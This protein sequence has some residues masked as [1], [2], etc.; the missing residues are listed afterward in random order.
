MSNVIG[1]LLR[2]AKWRI[3]FEWK[4]AKWRKLQRTK[5]TVTVQTK[6]GLLT[7]STKDNCLSRELF[8]HGSFQHDLIVGALS[9]LRANGFV[10]PKENGCVLDIGANNGVISIGI[11][12]HKQMQSA[13]GIEP[14]PTNFELLKRNIT[15]NKLEGRYL[16]LQ[17][18]ASNRSG[19]V[20]FEVDSWNLGNHRVRLESSASK[21]GPVTTMVQAEPLDSVIASLPRESAEAIALAWIDVQGH[22]G[23]VFEGGKQ[24]FSSGIPTVAEIWPRGIRE[25]GMEPARFCEIVASLWS[26]FWVWRR[27]GAFVSYPS[28]HMGK[29]M[30][31]LGDGDNNFEDVIFTGKSRRP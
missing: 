13:I 22:E 4:S 7:L 28:E 5:D 20:C 16:P 19:E 2:S 31:E 14:D 10:P 23:Y 30:E 25:S 29:F 3:W 15:D 12:V 21:G 17:I 6:H 1:S 18:A 26:E 8:I 9:F 27:C 11:L 24:F